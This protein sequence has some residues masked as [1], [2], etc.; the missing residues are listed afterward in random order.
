[1]L[2]FTH[3]LT[4]AQFDCVRSLLAIQKYLAIF[5]LIGICSHK[6][7]GKG[8]CANITLKYLLCESL[9]SCF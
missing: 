9:D 5:F 8:G 4:V 7:L 3:F 2:L 6:D 1:M